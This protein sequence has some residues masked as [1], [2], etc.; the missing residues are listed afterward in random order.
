MGSKGKSESDVRASGGERHGGAEEGLNPMTACLPQPQ[1]P[2]DEG[3]YFSPG[4]AAEAIARLDDK[5]KATLRKIARS[6]WEERMSGPN[7]AAEPDDLLQEAMVRT[8]QGTRRW[9]RS[10]TIIKH[11]I[12]TMESISWEA[13]RARS[14]R[15]HAWSEDT[16]DEID[17]GDRPDDSSQST[18]VDVV[19]AREELA[20]IESRFE[21]DREALEVLRCRSIE[22]PPSETCERL[23][24]DRYCYNTVNKR[25]WRKLTNADKNRTEEGQ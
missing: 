3:K 8:L 21:N 2:P 16:V 12:R 17:P 11:L 23:G 14:A 9:R 18:V 20:Q 13:Y 19:L 22:L 4:E 5:G 1:K 7:A 25:I 10:V 6:Y 24:I 15:T